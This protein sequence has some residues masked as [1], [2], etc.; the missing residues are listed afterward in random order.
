MARAAAGAREDVARGRLDPLPRPE[1]HRRDR[2]CP[3]RRGPRRRRAQPSSSAIRQSRPITSPPARAIAGSSVE[4]PVPKWI[5][6]TS[7]AARIRADHG[8]DE[9]L[10]VGRRERAD[11][12][13][14][15]LHDVGARARLRGDV[16]RRSSRRAS[17]SARARP[18][19]REY[20]SAFDGRELARRP[21][22]DEVAGDGERPAAEADDRL[23]GGELAAHDPDRLEQRRERLVGIG[24]AQ[25]LDV[26]ERAHRRLRS[27]GRRPRRARRRAPMPRTGVMMSANITAASTPWRRTGCSVTSA[28]SSGVLR[29]LQERVPLADRAVL[30]QR[31]ARLAHEPDRRA[32]DRLA[33]GGADEQRLHARSR[34]AAP[35]RR[36]RSLSRWGAAADAC[37][38]GRRA[39]S[40]VRGRARE[41]RHDRVARRHLPRLP[42]ARR[43]RQPDRLGR[44]CARPRRRSRPA[45]ARRSR[46]S[47]RGADPA[48]AVPAR[49]RPGRRA[50]RVVLGARQPDARRSTSTCGRAT[51]EP[52][53]ELPPSVEPA[54]GLGRARARRARRGLRRR[55]RRDRLGGR[56]CT[57]ARARSRRTSPG[58]GRVPGFAAPLA[59]PVGARRASSSSGS[60]TSPGLPAFAAPRDEPWVYDGRIVLQRQR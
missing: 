56:R 3:A 8:R 26:G 22:L 29:D 60:T 18:R 47:V 51:G 59:L 9:L 54:R 4:A 12:R 1:Q 10:V 30:G 27:P 41:R 13:V 5:V 28:Q 36:D 23:L 11:P 55:R 42:L 53:A 24:H 57:A 46:R 25:A 37:A 33:P 39:S 40:C 34:L 19:A 32:L 21:A 20:I 50:P 44:R 48:R 58:P 7:T 35:C 2:G 38:A 49:L 45:S 14:E 15:E 52:N 43:P 17:P 16:R 31:A 6:G